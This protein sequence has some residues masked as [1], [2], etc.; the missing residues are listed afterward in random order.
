MFFFLGGDRSR[1]PQDF[2]KTKAAIFFIR[3]LS[4]WNHLDFKFK[5]SLDPPQQC[6]AKGDFVSLT[7]R[8]GMSTGGRPVPLEITADN[9]DRKEH[10]EETYFIIYFCIYGWDCD[11]PP[12]ERS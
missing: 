9:Y 4:Y 12:H 10:I 7:R 2:F 11:T 6:Q 5:V 8:V 1:H 3:N